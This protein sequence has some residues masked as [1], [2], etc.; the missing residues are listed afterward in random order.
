MSNSLQDIIFQ[1]LRE[2]SF[3]NSWKKPTAI[4]KHRQLTTTV[5]SMAMNTFDKVTSPLSAVVRQRI[6]KNY[7]YT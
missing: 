4:E 6:H 7:S 2:Q 1:N 3:V 5:S